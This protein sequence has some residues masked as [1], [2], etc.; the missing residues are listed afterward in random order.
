[1]RVP[2]LKS[3]P[4]ARCCAGLVRGAVTAAACLSFASQTHAEQETVGLE[5]RAPSTCPDAAF[6]AREVTA[7]TNRV[8]FDDTDAARRSFRVV[9]QGASGKYSGILR[10]TA[11][12]GQTA[13]RNFEA[14]DCRNVVVAL[15]L[16]AA[17]SVDPNASTA[18]GSSS[19]ASSGEPAARARPPTTSLPI[20]D[21]RP[22]D[23]GRSST[24][25]IPAVGAGI[26]AMPQITPVTLLAIG[27]FLR[28]DRSGELEPSFRVNAYFAK[29]G[30]TG[31]AAQAADFYL[32]AG[33]VEACPVSFGIA[34][35]LRAWP[36]ASLDVGLLHA[37]GTDV[38]Q[39]GEGNTAW[40]S[41]MLGPRLEL[42]LSGAIFVEANAGAVWA[43]TQP[44]FVFVKPEILVHEVPWLT[45]RAGIA[46]GIKFP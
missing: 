23:A 24:T 39:P 46:G 15:A 31:P 3:R 22:R 32:V 18:P 14:E 33:R 20:V 38:A 40:V 17:L 6:F 2:A 30:T 36:C 8:R 42:D 25:W 26:D 7:R 19:A 5:Y 4:R 1:M 27:G 37:R 21:I 34:S 41:A 16:V 12:D 45:F 44:E 10:I 11:H 13:V 35:G 43:I 28:L 29:T 9:V